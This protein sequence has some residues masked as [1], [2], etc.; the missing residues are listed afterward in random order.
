MFLKAH[1]VLFPVEKNQIDREQHTDRVHP[2]R[3]YDPKTL[4]RARPSPGFSQQT[5]Q[6]A[7]IGIGH[8]YIGGDKALARSIEHTHPFVVIRHRTLSN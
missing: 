8:R 1:D 6:P 7:K 4:T 2:V 5:Y 3:G